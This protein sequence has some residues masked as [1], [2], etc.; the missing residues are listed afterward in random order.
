MCDLRHGSQYCVA[1]YNRAVAS[2]VW[3]Q[4]MQP[5]EDERVLAALSH[6]SIV[7]NIVNL[8]GMIATALIWTMQR[9]RSRFVRAHA[10]QSLVYQGAVLL[11]SIF[12]MLSW[13]LCVVL[14][15]LPVF[16]K[17]ELYQFS[18]PPRSFYFAL[19]G[20][21]VPIGFGIAGTIY[22]LYGA[23]QVYRGRPFRYPVVGRLV[24]RELTQPPMPPAETPLPAPPTEPLSTGIYEAPPAAPT[25]DG[26]APHAPDTSAQPPP[27]RRSRRRPPEGR[28]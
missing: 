2:N 17:P 20:L 12:L 26:E 21:I 14:S 18:S 23:Y 24:R 28:E 5:T 11:I 27:G 10:L 8:A 4:G 7:A 13:G 15:L 22:G 16:L 19:F 25:S 6:A 3:G 9:D 1:C